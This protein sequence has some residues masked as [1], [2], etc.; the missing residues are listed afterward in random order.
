LYSI[1]KLYLWFI[2]NSW[3]YSKHFIA[4]ENNGKG[5]CLNYL[6]YDLNLKNGQV[7][8]ITLDAQANVRLLDDIN[9]N[10]YKRGERHQYYGGLAKQTPVHLSAPRSGHWNLVIDLGGYAGTVNA[11]VKVKF[12]QNFNQQLE[13]LDWNA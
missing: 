9:F 12:R 5:G 11:G 7:V 2:S 6:H 3:L 10:K 8:E 4:D 1:A 13:E